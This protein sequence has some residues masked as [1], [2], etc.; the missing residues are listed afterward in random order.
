MSNAALKALIVAVIADAII[1]EAEVKQLRT[2]FYADG[3]IDQ[4]EADAMFEINDACTGND[5]HESYKT[6]FV[7]VLS[8]FVLKDEKTPG[9]VDAEEG[10]YLVDKIGADGQVDDQEKALLTHIR[11]NATSIESNPLKLLIATM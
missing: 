1:D 10:Q 7:E 6:L 4:E 3:V 9:V 11:D 8:D 5:N 2:Q